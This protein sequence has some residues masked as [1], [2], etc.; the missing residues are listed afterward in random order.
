MLLVWTLRRGVKTCDACTVVKAKPKNV[1]K[2]ND[3][4]KSKVVGERFF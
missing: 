1:I 2:I 3:H 4:V